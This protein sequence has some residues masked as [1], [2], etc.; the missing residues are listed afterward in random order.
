MFTSL[1]ERF[2]PRSDQSGTPYRCAPESSS[3]TTIPA[4]AAAT[5]EKPDKRKHSYH[6]SQ[7]EKGVH[8]ARRQSKR[9]PARRVTPGLPGGSRNDP[10]EMIAKAIKA[11]PGQAFTKDEESRGQENPPERNPDRHAEY[12]RRGA[13]EFP[14]AS[15][16][17]RAFTGPLLPGRFRKPYAQVLKPPIRRIYPNT[18]AAAPIAS[19][20]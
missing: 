17:S 16:V 20:T 13:G 11:I 6:D 7:V 12:G 2:L 19:H 18:M 14:I 15:S 10:A 4:A 1:Q 5:I 9:E 3:E 8:R